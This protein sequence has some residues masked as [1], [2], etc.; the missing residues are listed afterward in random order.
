MN[1]RRTVISRCLQIHELRHRKIVFC[2]CYC[3]FCPQKGSVFKIFATT[4][5]VE[6]VYKSLAG[7]VNRLIRKIR[8][9]NVKCSWP[10]E[11]AWTGTDLNTVVI[12]R[13]KETHTDSLQNVDAI[14]L[15]WKVLTRLFAIVKLRWKEEAEIKRSVGD[16]EDGPKLP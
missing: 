7:A 6:Q 1:G 15:L 2:C 8:T 4:F 16:S 11:K 10:L 14:I 5:Q 9:R 13:I 3:L 12:T